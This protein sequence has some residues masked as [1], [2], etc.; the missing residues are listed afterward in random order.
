MEKC[1]ITCNIKNLQT[2][3][4]STGL[5]KG[6]NKPELLINYENRKVMLFDLIN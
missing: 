1:L 2:T 5:K 6:S 3:K 4:M